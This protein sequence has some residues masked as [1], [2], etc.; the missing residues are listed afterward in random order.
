VPAGE[1]FSASQRARISRA[2]DAAQ[3]MCGLRF[4]VYVGPLGE[5][6]R[7]QAGRILAAAADPDRTVVVAVD[8]AAHDLEIV[9][10]TIATHRIDDRAAGLGALTMTAS[11]QAG[12]LTGGVVDGLRTLADHGH[13][14]RTLHT[15]QP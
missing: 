9:T 2:I 8:A 1:A 3:Q 12:D 15:V 7:A 4:V 6:P 14:P 11:F 13:Q 5:T 10:G